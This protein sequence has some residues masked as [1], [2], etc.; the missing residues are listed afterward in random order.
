MRQ[1]EAASPDSDWTFQA[2]LMVRCVF[3]GPNAIDWE[4]AVRRYSTRVVDVARILGGG[5]A[6]LPCARRAVESVLAF[7]TD[8]SALHSIFRWSALKGLD[9]LLVMEGRDSSAR[10]LLDSATRAGNPA[11]VS[12]HLF[13]ADAGVKLSEAPGDSAASSLLSRPVSRMPATRLRY[14]TLWSARTRQVARLDS[15]A[16]RLRLIA[17]STGNGSHRLAADGATAR[18]SLLSGDTATAISLLKGL[19]PAADP[20]WITWDVFES[21]AAERFLL[22]ELQLATGDAAAAWE[23]AESFD[24][25][26]SQLNQLYL[27]GS[28]SVRLRAGRVLGRSADRSRIEARLRALGREDLITTR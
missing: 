7:D 19:Q 2:D 12:L 17:D 15:I 4:Q 27:A 14:L 10:A 3:D 26:R 8:T 18:L 9:Y 23:T 5:G 24:S 25:P 22:A 11:S 20:G 6:H 28:L 21:A 1:I 13:N 16:T